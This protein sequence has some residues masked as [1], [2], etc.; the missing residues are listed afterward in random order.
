MNQVR[1]SA[2]HIEYKDEFWIYY[3]SKEKK[4]QMGT[5]WHWNGFAQ[6]RKL[7]KNENIIYWMKVGTW[8]YYI[9]KGVNI[10]NIKY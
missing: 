8:N 2:G 3:S 1:H 9:Q 4:K 6:Q 5:T 7:L 10:Q